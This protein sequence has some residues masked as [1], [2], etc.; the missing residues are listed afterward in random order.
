MITRIPKFNLRQSEL[1]LLFKFLISAN[2]NAVFPV[3]NYQSS[4]FIFLIAMLMEYSGEIVFIRTCFI[5]ENLN[6][7]NI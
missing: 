1:N 4:Y 3:S 6:I 2:L 5:F 7:S